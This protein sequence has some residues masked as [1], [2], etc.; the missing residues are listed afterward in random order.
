[1]LSKEIKADIAERFVDVPL[2]KDCGICHHIGEVHQDDDEYVYLHTH[3][4][5]AIKQSGYGYD[6]PSCDTFPI[7]PWDGAGGDDGHTAY[8]TAVN[9]NNLWNR[10]TEYGRRRHAVYNIMLD[11]LREDVSQS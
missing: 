1:M 10:T 5:N 11:N 6:E 2:N 8:I 9:S 7:K 3:L 4:R